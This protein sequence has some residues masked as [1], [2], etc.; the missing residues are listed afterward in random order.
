MVGK[1]RLMGSSKISYYN[2]NFLQLGVK[3]ILT[4]ADEKL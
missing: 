2:V 4:G 3:I 1:Y